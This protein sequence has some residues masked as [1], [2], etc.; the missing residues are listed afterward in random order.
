MAEPSAK[1]GRDEGAGRP[2]REAL[3][4]IRD[5][6][7]VDAP[8][9]DERAEAVAEV[10]RLLRSAAG[11]HGDLELV[12]ST[13]RITLG[14]DAVY[15]SDARD[16]NLAFELF[17]QGLRRLVFKPGLTDDEV[18]VFVRRFADSRDLE[19]VDEDFVS[20]LWRASLPGIQYVALDGFTERLF[21]AD[22]EFT[23]SFRAIVDDLYPGLVEMPD[24][25]VA[26][27][28]QARERVGRDAGELVDEAFDRQ[29]TA[30]K[31][32]A[33][34]AKVFRQALLDAIEPVPVV[35]HG[36]RLLSCFAV[37]SPC[38]ATGTEVGRALMYT[39]QVAWLR[40]G[41]TAYADAGR[42]LLALTRADFGPA[43]A[44]RLAEVRGLIAGR[45]AVS[46]AARNADP[47]RPEQTSWLRWYFISAGVL[48][49]PDLLSLIN[50]APTPNA[51]AMLR[52]LLRRQGTSSMEPWAEQLRGGDP[53]VVL[54]VLEVIL[55]SNLGPQAEPLLIELLRHPSPEVRGRAIDGLQSDYSQAMRQVLLPM[56]RDPSPV[57]RLAVLGRFVSAHDRSV[58]PYIAG[59]IKAPV[60]IEAEEDEQRAFFEALAELGGER[61]LE[62]FSERLAL[63]EAEGGA[64]GRLFGKGAQAL[65]DTPVRRAALAGLARL[66]TPSAVALIRE[67]QGRADLELASQCEVAVRLAQKERA[68]VARADRPTAQ[69]VEDPAAVVAAGASALGTRVLF[70]PNALRVEAP[71]RPRPTPRASVPKEPSS[72][73]V[74]APSAAPP[75]TTAR[76][77]RAIA[78]LPLLAAG[79]V[80]LANDERRL[81]A[82]PSNL[83]VGHL[84]FTAIRLVLVGLDAERPKAEPARRPPAARAAPRVVERATHAAH[85]DWTH[86]PDASLV[87]ILSSYLDDEAED[88]R[89]AKARAPARPAAAPPS[90]QKPAAPAPPKPSTSGP[91]AQGAGGI[92]DVLKQFL[93][94][95]LD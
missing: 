72:P 41:M 40:I 61:T 14:D 44:D 34:Q 13:N 77:P 8:T 51:Q 65:G 10:A 90:S 4:R 89:P 59:S 29:R 49:A 76:A 55:G 30:A 74:R 17:R 9:G 37:K 18:D 58:A 3:R 63:K 35:E 42:T 32:L 83:E 31:A 80:F 69:A 75:P 78:D 47:E 21:M 60:F 71:P 11:E 36:L 12:I 82:E 15:K 92:D 33:A 7:A 64:L 26:D 95:D 38:A 6:T 19:K 45:E 24:D 62:V 85:E 1:G 23:T 48:T 20:Q 68:P 84:K 43:F 94:L 66:G 22:E 57:V 2:V 79:E 56:L 27:A 70:D 87:D 54:E 52:D 39:M 46:F 93:D 16:A 25:D 86:Q 28:P 88:G 67:L 5:L 73:G 50:A 53:K 91:A 81:R